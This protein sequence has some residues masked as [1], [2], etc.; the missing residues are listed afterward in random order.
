MRSGFYSLPLLLVLWT[1]ALWGADGDKLFFSREFPGSVPEYFDVEV[2]TGGKVIYRESLDDAMPIEFEAPE[3]DISRLF[4]ISEQ[5]E[6]FERPFAAP[7]RETA[8]TGNKVLRYTKSS[9]A[10]SQVE[11]VLA[12]DQAVQEMISWFVRVADTEWHRINIERAIQFDRLGVNKAILQF[13][14]AFDKGRVVAPR[15]FLPLL[16]GIANDMKILHLARSRAA[17]LAERIE[18]GAVGTE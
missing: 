2:D 17:G 6:Y 10:T 11:F 5:L 14:A 7:K 15:Q 13:H 8:F 16:Q 3:A 18:A 12:D 9:G 1:A 4:E